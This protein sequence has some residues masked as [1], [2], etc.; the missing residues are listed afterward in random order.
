MNC[1]PRRQ[2]TSFFLLSV[3]D[4]ARSS[5]LS[6][7]VMPRGLRKTHEVFMTWHSVR[8]RE[9][10]RSGE[11]TTGSED[12]SGRERADTKVTWSFCPWAQPLAHVFP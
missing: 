10:E 4:H 8:R 11:I 7:E 6:E 12:A 5:W 3:P 1:V 9:K 2:A